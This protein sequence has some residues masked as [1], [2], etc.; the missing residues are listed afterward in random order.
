MEIYYPSVY[1]N[2]LRE[3]VRNLAIV[4]RDQAEI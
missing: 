3:N 1:M 4:A 2:R